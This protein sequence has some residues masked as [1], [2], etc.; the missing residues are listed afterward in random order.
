MV[1]NVELRLACVRVIHSHTHLKLQAAQWVHAVRL[2][3]HDGGRPL[4]VLYVFFSMHL[5]SAQSA[6]ARCHRSLRSPFFLRFGGRG[7]RKPLL[8]CDG[9]RGSQTAV[10]YPCTEM[11]Q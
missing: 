2:T 3:W 10:P 5:L 11:Y 7:L 1:K 8:A 9:L 6:S 4:R